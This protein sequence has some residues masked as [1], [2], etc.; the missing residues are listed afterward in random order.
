MIIENY[1]AQ[2]VSLRLTKDEAYMLFITTDGPFFD[3]TLNRD[4]PVLPDWTEQEALTFEKRI[5]FFYKNLNRENGVL[6]L[7][8][9]ELF[10][11][12]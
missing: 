12:I 11:L 8:N 2:K 3:E 6:A 7:S 9:K 10:Y 4:I 5:E 1:D